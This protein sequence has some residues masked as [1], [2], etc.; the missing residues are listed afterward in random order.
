MNIQKIIIGLLLSITPIVY[1]AATDHDDHIESLCRE[2]PDEYGN[3]PLIRAVM[4]HDLDKIRFLLDKEAKI[5]SRNN[6]QETPLHQA[7]QDI[8]QFLL[9]RGA[10]VNAQDKNG[11]TVFID[12]AIREHDK[13]NF[14]SFARVL[15]RAGADVSL[16]N[17][18][19]VTV[20]EIARRK[21]LPLKQLIIEE[22][23]RKEAYKK[24]VVP[25]LKPIIVTGCRLDE[26]ALADIIMDYAEEV[27][28]GW[29]I[30]DP[31]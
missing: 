3:T 16:S 15:L 17:H 7:S 13:R 30:G 31:V 27:P 6:N 10:D 26:Q 5:N 2:A 21:Y 11:N 8:F 22:D 24:I 23:Q 1:G 12:R 18:N 25:K 14:S 19:G 28:M 29:E 4:I 9:S 20:L